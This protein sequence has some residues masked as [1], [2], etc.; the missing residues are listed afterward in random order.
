[1]ALC[2]SSVENAQAA[3]KAHGLPP[4]M[5]A[6]GS[7][8]DLADDLEIDLVVCSVRVDRHYET[9]VPLLKAGKDV[10]CEWPLGKNLAEAQEMEEIAKSKGVRTV[11][12]LQ[13]WQSPFGNKVKEIVESGKIGKVLSTTFVGNPGFFG[14]KE[15]EYP[16]YTQ[17]R[18]IGRNMVTICF[19]HSMGAM[20]Y[21]LGEL[22]SF[23]S[24]IEVKRP[25]V[26]LV[27]N[28]GKF[29]KTIPRTSH[30]QILV[31]GHLASGAL[32]SYHLRGGAAFGCNEGLIWRIYGETGEIKV[33][34]SGT[35]LQ[36]GHPDMLIRLHDHSSGE[37]AAIAL[38][39]D[40]LGKL[41]LFSQ[42]I[43]RIYEAFA[44]GKTSEYPDWSHAILRHKLVEEIYQREQ[45]GTQE[46]VARYVRV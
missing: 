18:E 41:P 2:N 43:G 29:V 24:V 6:Y 19:I 15:P 5:K 4:T 45:D 14:L 10:F 32:I 46:T 40:G 25:E 3:I 27:D 11:V 26:Q 34:A 28:T 12:R 44:D 30:D 36:I 17:D 22:E 35:Y 38:N 16:A 42:N 23:N 9:V 21:A 7:P 8:Q 1:M 13:V 39:E 33:T 20:L 31:Q 37:T